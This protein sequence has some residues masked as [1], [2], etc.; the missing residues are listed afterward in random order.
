MRSSSCEE[1]VCGQRESQGLLVFFP[2]GCEVGGLSSVEMYTV[3][4]QL[5]T[6]PG[7]FMPAQK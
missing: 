5:C 7:A 6:V 2:L 1:E 4:G 3:G